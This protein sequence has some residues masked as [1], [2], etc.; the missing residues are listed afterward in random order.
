MSGSVLMVPVMGRKVVWPAIYGPCAIWQMGRRKSIVSCQGW[1]L[2]VGSDEVLA[3]TCAIARQ[4]EKIRE[5]GSSTDSSHTFGRM[6]T[7]P[8]SSSNGSGGTFFEGV[9]DEEFLEFARQQSGVHV[10]LA[11]EVARI[12]SSVDAGLEDGYESS[13]TI[14]P[15]DFDRSVMN[16]GQLSLIRREKEVVSMICNECRPGAGGDWRKRLRLVQ[17][18]MVVVD[19]IFN[20]AVVE[21]LDVVLRGFERE[22]DEYFG[23][24]AE[25]VSQAAFNL[26]DA[27]RS[28]KDEF[29]VSGRWWSVLSALNRTR[30]VYSHILFA[31]VGTSGDWSTG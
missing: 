11:N 19:G 17:T 25:D 29:G 2:P 10:R 30:G 20:E 31:E 23:L 5:V 22:L 6:W 3:L 12:R 18:W 8:Q 4:F 9:T 26:D 28:V 14:A 16:E 1:F 13:C 24:D 27:L 7:A 21:R 15:S